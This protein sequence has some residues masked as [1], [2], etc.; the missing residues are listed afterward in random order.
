M[1]AG[2]EATMVVTATPNVSTQNWLTLCVSEIKEAYTARL[3]DVALT[4]NEGTNTAPTVDLASTTN[5][6]TLVL[7]AAACLSSQNTFSAASNWTMLARKDGEGA[8][9]VIRRY[10]STAGNY[11]PTFALAE[12][13]SWICC[14]LALTADPPDVAETSPF[15][16]AVSVLPATANLVGGETQQFTASVTGEGPYSTAVT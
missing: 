4:F 8:L 3:V 11:D 7:G 12:S 10:A 13:D 2:T 1:L 5:S 14:G 6:K 15:V 9:A 16:T